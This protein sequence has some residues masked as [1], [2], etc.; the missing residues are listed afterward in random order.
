MATTFSQEILFPLPTVAAL[1]GWERHSNA[2]TV[3]NT[4]M[5]QCD[6]YQASCIS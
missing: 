1:P 6:D 2:A 3:G 4:K 5:R